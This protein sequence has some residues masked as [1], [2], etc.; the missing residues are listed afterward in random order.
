MKKFVLPVVLLVL[1]LLVFAAC[2]S[3]QDVDQN[4]P[5]I[6]AWSW[7]EVA[8]DYTYT[9]NADG[10]GSRGGVM[11]GFENFTW[12]TTNN[13]SRLE[14]RITNPD[15]GNLANQSWNVILNGNSLTLESRQTDEVYHYTRVN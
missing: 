12:W 15:E 11:F 4:N 8:L 5:L 10:T 7:D 2:N 6:G 3:S 1:G 14:L 13:D 9:F